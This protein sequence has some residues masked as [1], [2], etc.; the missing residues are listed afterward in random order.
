MKIPLISNLFGG[1][2]DI[3]T[4]LKQSQKF[5]KG[6]ALLIMRNY[7]C[8]IING[9][10]SED[11]LFFTPIG[12]NRK[13]RVRGIY[14]LYPKNEFFFI[15]M[16]EGIETIDLKKKPKIK[17]FK[18][19]QKNIEIDKKGDIQE[20]IVM[21]EYEIKGADELSSMAYLVGRTVALKHMEEPSKREILL[22]AIICIVSGILLGIMGAFTFMGNNGGTPT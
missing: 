10:L 4:G 18:F 12:I 17:K 20:T 22:I 16:D 14:N 8:S 21:K 2:S 1:V 5:H 7:N 3:S 6:R 15:I 11:L 13:Y 9:F 19:P